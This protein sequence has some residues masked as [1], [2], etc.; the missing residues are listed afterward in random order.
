M[1]R[2]DTI[3]DLPATRPDRKFRIL[4]MP[5]ELSGTGRLL[6]TD[7]LPPPEPVEQ[8]VSFALLQSYPNPFNPTIMPLTVNAM[9]GDQHVELAVYD[10][11][12][13]CAPAARGPPGG[14][15]LVRWDGIN[16]ENNAAA[17]GTYLYTFA[18]VHGLD[19]KKVVLLRQLHVLILSSEECCMANI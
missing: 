17:S 7:V 4:P 9:Y 13:W 3:P 8:P 10:A 18:Q 19:T 12:S 2:E 5:R 11:G 6:T 14:H 15:Y 16:D 1:K